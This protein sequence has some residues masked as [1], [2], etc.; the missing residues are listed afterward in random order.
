MKLNLKQISDASRCL[1]YFDFSLDQ[2]QRSRP[3]EEA[4]VERVI[5]K[6][7]I[8]ATETNFKPPWRVILNW[9]NALAYKNVDEKDMASWGA[10]Q[11]V[12]EHCLMFLN[13]WYHEILIPEQVHAFSGLTVQERIASNEI[14]TIIPV[15]KVDDIPTIVSVNSVVQ[16]TWELYNDIE[17]R[18]QAWLVMKQLNCE[19][20]TYQ[21]LTIGPRGGFSELTIFIDEKASR[22]TMKMV[23]QVS[24]LIRQGVKFPSI[25]ETCKQCPFKRRCVI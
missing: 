5:Q 16:S 3:C 24:E 15:V 7:Y 14:T 22:R 4:I 8:R 6:C 17:V 2:Q 21:R 20:L 19:Q 10:C 23:G 18:T 11:L 13:K 1:R 12:A 9:V 25:S